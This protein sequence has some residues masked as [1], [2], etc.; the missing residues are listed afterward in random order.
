MAGILLGS[1]SMGPERQ[2]KEKRE[3]AIDSH[4]K[5]RLDYERT[6]ESE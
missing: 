1:D 6:R 5:I 2:G 3:E 4:Y